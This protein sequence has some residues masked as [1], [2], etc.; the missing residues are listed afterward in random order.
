MGTYATTTALNT[1][2]FGYNFDTQTTL[3]ADKAIT[4]AER[5]IDKKLSRRYDVSDFRTT[6]PPLVT[7]LCETYALGTLYELMSRG[8][9]EMLA[10]GASL[11]KQ[12]MENLDEIAA[13][14]AD[15]CDTA[16][17]VIPDLLASGGG[18]IRSNTADYAPT[19]AEDNPLRWKVDSQ[20]LRD[21]DSDR[22]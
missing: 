20:K 22:D 1:L 14:K 21:I 15:I 9:K 2:M 6:V 19:F 16:G 18:A 10:Q 4:W 7:S 3:L 8:G 13:G 11:K 17:S 12:V 5:E